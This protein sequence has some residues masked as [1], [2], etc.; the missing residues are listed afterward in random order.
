MGGGEGGCCSLPFFSLS[1]PRF[2]TFW[3]LVIR[4]VVIQ[5][6]FFP[7]TMGF[8]HI[9]GEVYRMGKMDFLIYDNDRGT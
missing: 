1:P 6:A 5:M 8:S 9:Y 7:K 3:R 2:H 4:D